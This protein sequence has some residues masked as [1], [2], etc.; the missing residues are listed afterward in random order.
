MSVKGDIMNK[1][2]IEYL[3]KNCEVAVTTED[4]DYEV[5]TVTTSDP[6]CFFYYN[7]ILR[8]EI[9]NE[10]FKNATVEK[11]RE[12]NEKVGLKL[13]SYLPEPWGLK[14]VVYK[15]KETGRFS[16]AKSYIA[17]VAEVMSNSSDYALMYINVLKEQISKDHIND[18]L[19]TYTL[20]NKALDY[21][22]TDKAS[23]NESIIKMY[24]GE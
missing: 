10:D 14:F 17:L 2:L 18:V 24:L 1:V 6:D 12:L 23:N 7:N 4:G 21:K 13:F 8:K 9:T 5:T 15:N 16:L 19:N 22:E 3:A 20:V 11:I